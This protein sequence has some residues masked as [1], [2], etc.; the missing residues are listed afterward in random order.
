MP[1]ERATPK[2]SVSHNAKCLRA[3]GKGVVSLEVG[4]ASPEGGAAGFVVSVD[5]RVRAI[6]FC[7]HNLVSSSFILFGITTH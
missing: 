3:E 4:V 2:A 6:V 1:V 5:I 7:E